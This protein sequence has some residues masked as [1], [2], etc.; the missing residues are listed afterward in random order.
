MFCEYLAAA[1]PHITGYAIYQGWTNYD[2]FVVGNQE[3]SLN[4]IYG[5]H[6]FLSVVKPNVKKT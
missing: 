5:I 4:L 3:H 2:Q 1:S 6:D